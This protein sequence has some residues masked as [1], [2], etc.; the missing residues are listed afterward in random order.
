LSECTDAHE[1][2]DTDLGADCNADE[3]CNGDADCNSKSYGD[4]HRNAHGHDSAW[5]LL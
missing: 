3:D 1:N 2:S 4:L 5:Q